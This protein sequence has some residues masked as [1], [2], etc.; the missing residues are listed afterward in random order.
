MGPELIDDSY[1]ALPANAT[2]VGSAWILAAV[3]ITLLMTV[4]APF[5]VS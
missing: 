1:R 2:E 5:L 3:V 4:V